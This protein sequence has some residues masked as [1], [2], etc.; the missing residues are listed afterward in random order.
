MRSADLRRPVP[1]PN[2]ERTADCRCEKT[3]RS[4]P[5]VRFVGRERQALYRAEADVLVFE[6]RLAGL[7][8]F[9][10]V[11]RDLYR[12]AFLGKRVQA[13]H[14]PI[15]TA[16]SGTIQIWTAGANGASW[17][18]EASAARQGWSW[19][20]SVCDL[21]SGVV[22]ADFFAFGCVTHRQNR[23]VPARIGPLIWT[24]KPNLPSLPVMSKLRLR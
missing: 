19:P 14:A 11:E 10:A 18:A 2:P 9:A 6:L 13:S 1:H 21:C 5:C 7:Q 16:T 12:R 15:A 24:L 23:K 4:S 3:S 20:V 8:T 17:P 22:I